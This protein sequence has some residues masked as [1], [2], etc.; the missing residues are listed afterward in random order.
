MDRLYD[1]TIVI[2]EGQGT[3]EMPARMEGIQAICG[4]AE[5]WFAN[6]EVHSIKATGPFCGH[7][8]D[9][10]VVEFE[11]DTTPKSTGERSQMREV[12]LYTIAH[13]K[14]VQEEFLYVMGWALSRSLRRPPWGLPSGYTIV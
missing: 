4:K 2:I 3:D 6:N 7:R 10:F 5:W 9:Q 12:G 11:L 13:G 14:I 1:E 8:D